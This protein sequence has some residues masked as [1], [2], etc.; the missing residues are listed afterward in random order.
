MSEVGASDV[1][2]PIISPN[3][4]EASGKITSQA[5]DTKSIVAQPAV[6]ISLGN[7]V[8][9]PT[10]APAKLPV[11]DPNA[12]S[13]TLSEISSANGFVWIAAHTDW[14]LVEA[15]FGKAIMERDRSG[16]NGGAANYVSYTLLKTSGSGVPIKSSA[17]PEKTNPDVIPSPITV[18]DFSF[19]SAGSIYSITNGKDGTLIGMK[20]GQPWKI[21]E[22]TDPYSTKEINK[23]VSVALDTLI[24][25]NTQKAGAKPISALNVSA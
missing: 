25:L 7:G 14:S 24:S 16:V 5:P 1:T 13:R 19:S 18:G 11:L 21:W 4:Q 9:S 15:K 8:A 2:R 3:F 17:P 20:D 12:V 22:T 10:S 23:G 6:I